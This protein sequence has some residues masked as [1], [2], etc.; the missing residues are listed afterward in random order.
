[1]PSKRKALITSGPTYE[2]IDPVR[3]IGNRSSGKQGHAIAAAMAAAGFEVT[4]VTGPVQ[5]ADPAGVRTIHV[6]TA[7][8]MLE[9][10]MQ[11]LPV[12]VAI[13]AAAVGDWRVANLAAQ[14]LKKEGASD[15]LTLELVQNPDILHHIATHPTLRPKLVVGFA[16]ETEQVIAHA[17]AKR[18]RKG[19]DWMLANPVSEGMGFDAEEN[20]V[21]LIADAIAE[22][23]P[24]QSKQAIAQALAA[25]VVDYLG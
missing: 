1:M 25:R 22:P 2:P 9:A 14:K 12:D 3:F 19:C 13:C 18:I 23:W 5:L 4:L 10:C 24:T 17:T 21:T 11:A 16:A 6:M 7:E 15:R 8:Q 20:R